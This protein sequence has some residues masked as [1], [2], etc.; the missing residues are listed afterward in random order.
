LDTLARNYGTGIR[1]L[2]FV[3]DSE[4]SRRK[5]NEWV[6]EQTEQR[7]E[8]LIP[9]EIIDELTRLVLT[10]AIYFN[11]A[12][13]FPFEESWTEMGNY[14]LLDGDQVEVPM[15]KQAKGFRYGAGDR[16]QAVELPYTG[17]ELSMVLIVPDLGSFEEI[18]S[19]I[20]IEFIDS[21]FDSLTQRQ[22]DLRM[23]RFE[24]ESRLRLADTLASMGMPEAFSMQA[25]FSGMDGTRDLYIKDVLHQAFIS[26]DESG[27]EAAAATAVVM[28]LKSA[29]VEEPIELVIDRPFVFLIRDIETGTILFLG[30]VVNPK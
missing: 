13:E 16:Y 4:G 26:V 12:W 15:M 29:P 5:I 17:R 20:N 22:I 7:I 18:E 6:S 1:L 25:N 2:D 10:N 23:P 27:T 28:T 8:E 9:P 14:Y 11:A 19:S 30:R 21:V 24:F 3:S